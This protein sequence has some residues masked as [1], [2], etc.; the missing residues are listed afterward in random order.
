MDDNRFEFL[1]GGLL[2]DALSD[3][4]TSELA[5]IARGHP[6]DLA[7]LQF[8]LETADLISQA[9]DELRASAMFVAATLERVGESPFV[10]GVREAMSK[11]GGRSGTSWRSVLVGPGWLH[12]PRVWLLSLVRLQCCPGISRPSFAS[13]R[14]TARCNGPA[15]ADR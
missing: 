4:E 6:E 1:M 8:Q 14:S 13:P 12:R 11:E 9:E 5:Q 7:E 3:E 10:A 15:T 2:D